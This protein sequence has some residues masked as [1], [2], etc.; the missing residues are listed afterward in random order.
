MA[1]VERFDGML[2]AMA[3]QLTGGIEELLDTFFSFLER[4]TD[5]YTGTES[6]KAEK[7]VISKFRE[8]QK[9]A[10]KR[11]EVLRKEK[12]EQEERRHLKEQKQQESRKREEIKKKAEAA[13]GARIVELDDDEAAKLKEEIEAKERAKANEEADTSSAVKNNE[14]MKTEDSA[15]EDEENEEDK[16]KLKPNRLNGGTYEHYWFGQTLSELEV[17]VPFNVSFPIKSKD[18]IC[19]IQQKHLKVSLKGH[20]PII[21]EQLHAKVKPEESFWTIEDRKLL[22]IHLEKVLKSSDYV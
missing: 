17:R 5:F 18:V 3:Q 9:K 1:D 22:V 11:Q 10:R 4:K 7:L 8:H 19:D 12:A 15:S 2:L 14:K 21:D 20:K 16:G 13:S 6:S